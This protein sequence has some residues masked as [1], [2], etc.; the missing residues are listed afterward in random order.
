MTAQLAATRAYRAIPMPVYTGQTLTAFSVCI[1]LEIS[2][3]AEM[4][5]LWSRLE[6]M[7]VRCGPLLVTVM[8]SYM[9]SIL[10]RS[11]IFCLCRSILS[12]IHYPKNTS[13][14]HM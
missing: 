9:R 14:I 7:T 5:C 2:G 13:L 10:H 11:A 6:L 8:V 1:R 12:N 3:I 4:K